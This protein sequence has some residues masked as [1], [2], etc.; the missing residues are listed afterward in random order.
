MGGLQL[1]SVL[2]AQQFRCLGTFGRGLLRVLYCRCPMG[3]V[4]CYAVYIRI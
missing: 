1:D 4:Q 3:A 2:L